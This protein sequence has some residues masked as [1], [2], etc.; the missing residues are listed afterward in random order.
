MSYSSRPV[1]PERATAAA[2]R[3]SGWPRIGVAGLPSGMPAHDPPSLEAQAVP[4]EPAAA[5]GEVPWRPTLTCAHR[6]ARVRRQP[7]ERCT[8]REA[9]W[10][11]NAD[12]PAI[13]RYR[14]G[15]GTPTLPWR[16]SL[17]RSSGRW[18]HRARAGRVVSGPHRDEQVV[19]GHAHWHHNRVRTY[20]ISAR[21]PCDDASLLKSTRQRRGSPTAGAVRSGVEWQVRRPGQPFRRLAISARALNRQPRALGVE[22]GAVSSGE[23][24]NRRCTGTPPASRRGS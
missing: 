3:V 10:F 15:S 19:P 13:G 21:Q 18:R 23:I 14:R 5:S 8:W 1:A 12:A 24:S 9:M 22:R 11:G 2:A 16:P 4:A 6:D 7:L 17:P 20:V